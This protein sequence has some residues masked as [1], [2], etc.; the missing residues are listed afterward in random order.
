MP[1][2]LTW[3]WRYDSVLAVMMSQGEVM[4]IVV[5]TAIIV[6]IAMRKRRKK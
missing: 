6:F 2:R 3:K 5:M 1:G 4:V